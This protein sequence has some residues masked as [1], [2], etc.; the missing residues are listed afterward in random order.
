M[1]ITDDMG[2][3]II[4]T[5]LQEIPPNFLA[6]TVPKL[7]TSPSENLWSWFSDILSVFSRISSEREKKVLSPNSSY[8]P[9]NKV[10]SV[11]RGDGRTELA[12]KHSDAKTNK[13]SHVHIGTVVL[14]DLQNILDEEGSAVVKQ[15]Q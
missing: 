5:K 2:I 9:N 13:G 8:L 12:Y 10:V 6:S 7:I 4:Y 14:L 11:L 3:D 1:P 15:V